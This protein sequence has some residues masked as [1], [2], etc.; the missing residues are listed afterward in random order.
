MPKWTAAYVHPG[1]AAVEAKEEGPIHTPIH[2]EHMERGAERCL[3]ARFLK[4]CEYPRS[5]D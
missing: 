5:N 3:F 4:P 2:V 1:L